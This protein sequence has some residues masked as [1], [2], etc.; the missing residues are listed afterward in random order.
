MRSAAPAFVDALLGDARRLAVPEG[1]SQSPRPPS[2][3]A[4]SCFL[5]PFSAC[6][7]CLDFLEKLVCA[8]GGRP[9][10]FG[11]APAEVLERGLAASLGLLALPLS[12]G[13][14]AQKLSR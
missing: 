4:L 14:L 3:L 10:A 7:F 5:A 11:H 1:S 13:V 9:V 2:F 6:L 8:F 12:S